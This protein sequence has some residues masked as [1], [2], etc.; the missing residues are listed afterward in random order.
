MDIVEFEF[1]V[2]QWGNNIEGCCEGLSRMQL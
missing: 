1:D 2:Y